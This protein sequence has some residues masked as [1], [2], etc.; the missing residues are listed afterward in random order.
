MAARSRAGAV[1]Q[2]ALSEANIAAVVPTHVA[3]VQ[4]TSVGAVPANHFGI[5]ERMNRPEPDRIYVCRVEDVWKSHIVK[6]VV[7]FYR[8]EDPPFSEILGKAARKFQVEVGVRSKLYLMSRETWKPMAEV[9]ELIDIRDGE[10]LAL[11][12]EGNWFETQQGAQGLQQ[13]QQQPG[14]P[15][16]VVAGVMAQI[17]VETNPRN[18]VAAATTKHPPQIGLTDSDTLTCASTSA[19]EV[20]RATT[21]SSS[22]QA[23]KIS[24]PGVAKKPPAKKPSAKIK[25]TPSKSAAA[26]AAA[27][28]QARCAQ[29]LARLGIDSPMLKKM[30]TSNGRKT[31]RLQDRTC[32]RRVSP[33][34]REATPI[35]ACQKKQ[36]PPK[37]SNKDN[38]TSSKARN[39]N[40]SSAVAA[41]KSCSDSDSD[42]CG[43]DSYPVG[44]FYFIEENGILYPVQIIEPTENMKMKSDERHILWVNYARCKE[45]V[46]ISTLLQSTLERAEKSKKSEVLTRRTKKATGST[47]STEHTKEESLLR[48][49]CENQRVFIAGPGGVEYPA[50]FI[51]ACPAAKDKCWIKYQN[52]GSKPQKVLC[53]ELLP[54]TVDREETYRVLMEYS[55]HIK[56]MKQ[57]ERKRKPEIVTANPKSKRVKVTPIKK[58]I[59]IAQRNCKNSDLFAEEEHEDNNS[60]TTMERLYGPAT[61]VSD[62]PT[63]YSVDGKK[64]GTVQEQAARNR[65]LYM[66]KENETPWAIAKRFAIPVDKILFDNRIKWGRMTKYSRLKANTPIVIPLSW[67][68]ENVLRNRTILNDEPPKAQQGEQLRGNPSRVVEIENLSVLDGLGTQP[69]PEDQNAALHPS[70]SGTTTAD[71]GNNIQSDLWAASFGSTASTTTLL[72]VPILTENHSSEG[73]A[74][75]G[76]SSTTGVGD[77]NNTVGQDNEVVAG[78]PSFAISCIR[79]PEGNITFPEVRRGSENQSSQGEPYNGFSSTTGVNDTTTSTVEHDNEAEAGLPF[80]SASCIPPPYENV[81]E[82]MIKQEHIED[83]EF[84]G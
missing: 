50:A 21:R 3:P 74:Y 7:S 61:D 35:A 25:M 17:T 2:A 48:H 60:F 75:N 34:G 28:K 41:N 69:P 18:A 68:G 22:Q 70:S 11:D 57:L 23:K 81:N 9:D 45:V 54:A 78:Q 66:S 82:T 20:P 53:T 29:E 71:D 64:C 62:L 55:A 76:S 16:A 6:K 31:R 24:K 80:F 56:R 14:A 10:D 44:G 26:I 30:V 58:R 32:S 37:S 1:P 42:E 77:N 65:L 40:T 39:K 19:P 59:P 5:A 63:Q 49:C 27:A 8:H 33:R 43:E 83:I 36:S 67:N 52:Y 72:E 79:P 4:R 12:V 73:Q 51:R 47:E 15:V 84:Q 38:A 13:Q 46:P